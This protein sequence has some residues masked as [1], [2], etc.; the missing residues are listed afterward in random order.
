MA[1]TYRGLACLLSY[2]TPAVKETV[3]AISQVLREENLLP[4]ANRKAVDA[5]IAEIAADDLYDL[6]ECYID[7]FD[8][9]RSLSLNLYEHVHG[10]S[11]E[12]GQAMV[13]LLELYRSRGLELDA[14]ELPDFLPVFLEF[15]S[16]LPQAEAASFLG[17]AVHV[18]EAMA[19]RL[20]KRDSRYQAVFDS[21]VALA[22]VRA[23]AG[24]V[25]A[26]LAEPE[27]DP[28]DLEAL[29]KTWEES[30]VTFGPGE[31]G[32]PKAEALVEAMR[33]PPKPAIARGA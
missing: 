5:L 22:G 12:R 4:A 7:I 16:I 3:G 18:L 1:L 24:V 19:V 14:N 11:R 2:P 31:A 17:E 28:D 30:A 8:R 29:D 6:Q 23:E 15:L 32:C 25:A 20:K 33:V 21:L 13:A 9:T 26:L 10:E 27:Q